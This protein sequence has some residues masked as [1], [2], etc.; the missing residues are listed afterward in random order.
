M[1]VI[2]VK[3]GNPRSTTWTNDRTVGCYFTSAK[4]DIERVLKWTKENLRRIVPETRELT[5]Q[6]HITLAGCS[7]FKAEWRA[8]PSIIDFIKIEEGDKM[9]SGDVLI[10]KSSTD[11]HWGRT[12]GQVRVRNRSR[13]RKRTRESATTS[14]W[15]DMK[16]DDDTFTDLRI[17]CESGRI[18]NG[19]KCVMANASDVFRTMFKSEMKAGS[20]MIDL[21]DEK[22]QAVELMMKHSYTGDVGETEEQTGNWI[23][24]MELAIKW[25][26]EKLFVDA[27]MKFFE[28]I[29][30]NNLKTY[31]QQARR[32]SKGVP[33]MA[34]VWQDIR[35]TVKRNVDLS[36]VLQK[37]IETIVGSMDEKN[38]SSLI[39][40]M[41][42]VEGGLRKGR[43]NSECKSVNMTDIVFSSD[44]LLTMIIQDER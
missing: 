25:E 37:E 34:M 1:I 10:W 7:C 31:M 35:K 16:D 26:L 15:N 39:S 13:S 33:V 11:T 30:P 17:K 6:D 14:I 24:I 3:I 38:R 12:G 9:K 41:S 27:K 23:Q 42:A 43:R 21:G 2:V 44:R 32:L 5:D 28:D 4:I 36:G 8:Y 40:E 22:E 20:A 19:H 18:F 29:K